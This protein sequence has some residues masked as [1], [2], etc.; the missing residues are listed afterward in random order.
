MKTNHLCYVLVCFLTACVGNLR[1]DEEQD[2]IAILKSNAGVPQKCDA[3]FRLRIIGT[4]RSVPALA[5]LL[6][7]ERLSQAA[8][9]ALEPMPYPE[10][11]QVLRQALSTGSGSIRAGLIDSLGWRRDAQAVPLLTPLLS[12]ADL[13]IAA[14]SASALGRIGGD[15]AV[16]ALRAVVSTAPPPVQPAVLEALLQYADDLLVAG[17]RSGAARIYRDLFS[18][19][20]LRQYRVA[21]WRGMVLADDGHSRTTLMVEALREPDHPARQAALE[22]IRERDDEQV[23]QACV[24]QWGSLAADAQLAVLDASVKQGRNALSLVGTALNSPYPAVQVAALEAAGRVGDAKLVAVLAERA[25]SGTE[26]QQAGARRSLTRLSGE[27]VDQA[28]LSLVGSSDLAVRVE[29]IDALRERGTSIDVAAQPLLDQARGSAPGVQRAALKALGEL[30][31]AEQMGDLVA[32]LVTQEKSGQADEVV[33]AL[34]ATAR[35]VAA[36]DRAAELVLQQLPKA[37]GPNRAAMLIALGQLGSPV[38]WPALRRAL[39]QTDDSQLREDALRALATGGGDDSFVPSL[40]EVSQTSDKQVH[41]VL[42]LRAAVRLIDQGDSPADGKVRQVRKVMQVAQRPDEKRVALAALA[43][44][45]TPA[46]MELAC[47]QVSDASLR[48]EAAQATVQIARAISGAEPKKVAA[49]LKVVAAAPVS[50]E[51]RKQAEDLLLEV[52]SVQS[53]LRNWEVA[54]PYM[55]EGQNYARLFDIPFAPED[56][57]AHVEWKPIAVRAEG[58][59]PAHVDLLAAFGGEQRVAYLRTQWEVDEPTAAMLEIY[60]DDGVKAWLNGKVIHA[61]NI[62][63]PIMPD[64]DRVRV[65]LQ[66]GINHLMLKVT[67][68][69]MPWGVIVRVK[70]VKIP[71]LKLGEGWRLHTINADSRFEAAGILDVNRDGKLDILSGGFW[72]EAP[73]W[74]RHFVREIKEEGDYFYDFANLPMD[75]DGDG[76]IDTAGAAWHNKMVYWVRNPG[77]ADG[78]WQL[79]EIDTPGNMETAMSYDIN[80]DGQPDILPDIMSE[81]AWYEFHRD[82]SAPQGVRWEKHPLPKEAAGHGLGAGDV[83]KDGRCDVVTPKGW[84]EQTADGGWQW[85]PEFDLGY[86][87]IPILVHDVDGDGDSDLVWGLAHNYGAYWLEQTSTGGKRTWEKYLI[88]DS[89]SQP[90]FLLMA[91]LDN[92]G[93]DELVTGKRY[94]AHNGHDPGG[95]EPCCVYYY[96]LEAAT[97]KWTRHVMHEGGRVGFGINT[98]AA[99]MDGD[100]DID[101]VAPG[102]S[103]LYL[104]ENLLK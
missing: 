42:A 44:I 81:A 77:K 82:A 53:Y 5:A 29:A 78:P 54:G 66:K 99:D 38:A 36:E 100:G 68:N 7:Q 52:A 79:F 40:L 55:R 91:D 12:D 26:A 49:A 25:A 15:D 33:K 43:R 71:Q 101:V 84:L 10:A 86:A 58:D 32:L 21:A 73:T 30:S 102:K 37:G 6:G 85:R 62:A 60:S 45:Q 51:S 18:G 13:V 50:A 14:A 69:N 31:G 95:E 34:V 35:R 65:T 96:D 20:S 11:G 48:A 70:E 97:K 8:C 74:K 24:R 63:R 57:G 19:K 75:V 67:Q 41:R 17:N 16:A 98:G 22:L 23:T 83:N 61:N 56:T 28:I 27:G 87:S 47:E 90:H 93:R 39:G 94:H 88:D 80:G 76:W 59:H 104:F 64:P 72:Y 1:A 92:D 89:W 4:A 3:C 103:G 2:L 46:A 9:N